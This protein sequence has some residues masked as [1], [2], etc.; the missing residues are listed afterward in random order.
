VARRAV[1]QAARGRTGAR[2]G[3]R[4]SA[5]AAGLT[6]GPNLRRAILIC[7]LPMFC[8]VFQLTA[9][10]A[11]LYALSKMW[12]FL[13]LPL[14]LLGYLT[15]RQPARLLYVATLAYVIPIPPL[16]AMIHLGSS[17]T[18]ALTTIV[19]IL[20]ISNFFSL[21]LVLAWLRPT[22]DEL[23]QA[24]TWL[25]YT[26]FILLAVL[27]VV[28][29]GSAYRSEFGL[30]TIFVGNDDVRGDRII[31]PMFFGLMLLFQLA[32][33]FGMDHRARHLLLILV[34]YALLST[35]Y[36]ERV[37]IIF[38]FAV[39][40]LGY[41]ESVMR[42]KATALAL[43]V[44]AG[45][46]VLIAG[47]AIIGLDQVAERLGGSLAVRLMSIDI[48]WHFLRDEPLRW[49]FGAGATTAFAQMTL[50]TMFRNPA[51][52]L[53]DIGWLGVIFEYGVVGGGLILAIHLAGVLITRNLVRA[54][55]PVSEALADYAIYLLPASLIYST[56]LVPGEIASVTAMAVYLHAA[57][58]REAKPWTRLMA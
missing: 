53:A 6:S 17:F 44:T 10:V 43:A 25:G 35:I 12:P 30:P 41:L 34:G 15:V 26:T 16:M 58:A 22:P 33:R 32:R 55:D 47:L 8:G 42:S 38:S 31:L 9:D 57:Q 37:P 21:A 3:G 29:P 45:L 46:G 4:T 13:M 54:S 28:I 1:T 14:A 23:R 24:V 27:W 36:K 48:A 7:V 40:C 51:F 50:N 19:K 49:I 5:N 11:P 18:E 56:A 52:F 2:T 20:P 39:I